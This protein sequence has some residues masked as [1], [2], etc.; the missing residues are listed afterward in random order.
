MK[1]VITAH[2]LLMHSKREVYYFT[3]TTKEAI[4]KKYLARFSYKLN[5]EKKLIRLAT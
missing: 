1:N 5:V 4:Q 3:C 2:I